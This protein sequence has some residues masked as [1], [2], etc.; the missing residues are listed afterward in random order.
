MELVVLVVVPYSLV[1]FFSFHKTSSDAMKISRKNNMIFLIDL[2][3]EYHTFIYMIYE[4]KNSNKL[5]K[6]RKGNYHPKLWE[7]K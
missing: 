2:V 5:L 4:T 1:F 6:T 7:T 3:E